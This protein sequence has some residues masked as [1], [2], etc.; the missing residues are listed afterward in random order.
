[1]SAD[2]RRR[3]TVEELAEITGLPYTQCQN[4]VSRLR[5]RGLVCEDGGVQK[6]YTRQRKYWRAKP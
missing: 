6:H 3:F 4:G 2:T 1:M 5:M